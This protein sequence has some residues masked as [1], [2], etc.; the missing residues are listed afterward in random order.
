MFLDARQPK[1]LLTLAVIYLKPP[2]PP[3]TPRS[4]HRG[5][6]PQ[7][8]GQR[9][10]RRAPLVPAA[11][12]LILGQVHIQPPRGDVER[13]DVAIP[14]QPDRPAGRG[15]MRF[16]PATHAIHLITSYRISLTPQTVAADTGFPLDTEGAVETP[17]ST[18]EEL[19]ILRQVVD[20][21]RT[22]LK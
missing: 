4:H 9:A 8:A 19:R 17:P 10:L 13:D 14:E 1:S 12:Q 3:P 6:A 2:T 18:P 11:R 20:Q 22:F 16:R 7:P 21:E 15:L 5:V